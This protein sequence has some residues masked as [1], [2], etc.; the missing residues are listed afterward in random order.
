LTRELG[1][2][3][4]ERIDAPAT[5]D[6]KDVLLDLSAEDITASEL[7]GDPIQALLT[8]APGNGVAIGAKALA[9]VMR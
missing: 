2:P 4:Y 7:A 9:G 5:P 8:T 6:P 3:V 1:A